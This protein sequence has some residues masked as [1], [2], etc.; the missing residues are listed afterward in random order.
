MEKQWVFGVR[1]A[2]GVKVGVAL[3]VEVG[4]TLGF[5]LGVAV[6]V[7]VGV[8]LGDTDGVALGVDVCVCILPPV[9]GSSL[10]YAC[11]CQDSGSS[12]Q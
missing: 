4:V 5:A 6:G 8:A 3:G 12:S 11:I 2:L 1:V 10:V 9:I 7:A